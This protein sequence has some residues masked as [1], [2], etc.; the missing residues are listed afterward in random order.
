MVRHRSFACVAA[1]L[2]LAVCGTLHPSGRQLTTPPQTVS[3]QGISQTDEAFMCPMHPDVIS[4]VPGEC[5]RC[6]MKLVIGRPYDMRDY[7]VELRTTPAI[8]KAGTKTTLELVVL[9]PDSNEIVRAFSEV[10]EKRYHLFLVS[11]DLEFFEHIHPEQDDEGKWSVQVTLPKPG[12]YKVISDFVPFGGSAQLVALP[13]VTA[14]YTRDLIEDTA[15]L[16]PDEDASKTVEGLTATVT[17]DPPRFAV[18][19]HSH[20]TFHLARADSHAPVTDLQTYLGAFGH[21]VIVSED[22]V[23][24][25]HSHPTEMLSPDADFESLRGGPDVMFEAAMPRAGRYRAWAQFR[26]NDVVRIFP[27]TFEV[28]G[29]G[30]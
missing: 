7:R 28:G 18:A 6:R 3:P 24:F 16:V 22:L 26:E 27:F 8:V 13:L 10:H 15:R 19:D 1:V 2:M 30:R 23:H 5:P 9:H 11:Q 20:L 12:H 29:N 21:I 14:G 25:V 4:D 17:Y